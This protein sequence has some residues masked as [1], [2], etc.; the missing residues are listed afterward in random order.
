MSLLNKF[1]KNDILCLV[2]GVC[3]L[4][5]VL[6]VSSTVFSWSLIAIFC[7]ISWHF[8]S[9][10][11]SLSLISVTITDCFEE[12]GASIVN[13][14]ALTLPKTD[15][16]LVSCWLCSL[17]DALMTIPKSRGK[18]DNKLCPRSSFW[19]RFC[20]QVEGNIHFTSYWTVLDIK[21]SGQ[22]RENF[23]FGLLCAPST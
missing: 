3:R 6:S 21:N 9:S 7:T 22:S 17:Q 15:R 10:C 11:L 19:N 12:R 20:Q 16:A 23:C 5:L 1:K 4:F 8:L 14:R 13:K 2:N 18:K